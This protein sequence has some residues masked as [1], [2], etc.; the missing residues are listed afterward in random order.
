MNPDNNDSWQPQPYRPHS[1]ADVQSNGADVP[2]PTPPTPIPPSEESVGRPSQPWQ[3]PV[4]PGGAPIPQPELPK[5][6]SQDLP[7]PTPPLPPRPAQ[8]A[9]QF[10][11]Q[12]NF[13]AAPSVPS[14]VAQANRP[15]N[16]NTVQNNAP[17]QFGGPM[18]ELPPIAQN[19]ALDSN[20][21]LPKHK[22]SHRG[23]IIW[24]TIAALVIVPAIALAI[25]F[26]A[27]V[28]NDNAQ[29][30]QQQ[31]QEQITYNHSEL[32]AFGKQPTA[33]KAKNLDK[34]ASFYTVFKKAAQEPIVQTTWDV[35]YTAKQNDFRGDQ[36]TMYS[37]TIDYKTKKYAFS[38][39]AVSNLGN[40]Q[41]RCIDQKQYTFNDSKL[42]TVPNW[43]LAS[44]STDCQFSVA[45]LYFNDGVNAGG[46]TA[47]Q[48]D[49]FLKKVKSGSGLKVEGLTLETYKEK[50]YLKFNVTVTPKL[51]NNDFIGMQ[52][53][54][55]AFQ[56]T[57]QDP[58]T[59]PYNYFGPGGEGIKMTYYVDPATLLPVH[60]VIDSTPAYNAA[61]KPVEM[62]SWPHRY[63]EYAFPDKVVQ[64]TLEGNTPI[65]F[66]TW[67]VGNLKPQ[68]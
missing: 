26:V 13:G 29:K 12:P 38:E 53:F 23:Q 60:A 35:Y 19:N 37:S 62:K 21:P 55:N 10:Q 47:D 27:S 17:Q 63:V 43:Q 46:L 15:V 33:E 11:G 18:A 61:G 56:A 41:T 34:T 1:D 20:H 5:V 25:Y 4:M 6:S 16:P 2:R 44:D 42:T 50:P 24:I 49:T 48:A 64:P 54:M 59:F 30:E 31:Q 66:S 9:S 65:G 14:Q 40:Y 52:A 68:Q 3:P 39:N 32:E 67:P 51:Q 28:M 58:K 7:Q 8:P 22:K 45:A 57:G 36:Y